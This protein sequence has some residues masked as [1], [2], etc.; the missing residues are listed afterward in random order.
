MASSPYIN[1]C[2]ESTGYGLP[3]F[4]KYIILGWLSK[5]NNFT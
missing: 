1:I 3:N 4:K 2:L 5:E